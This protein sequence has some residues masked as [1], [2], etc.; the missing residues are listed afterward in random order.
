[1][2]RDPRRL[3]PLSSAIQQ[4][5]RSRELLSPLFPTPHLGIPNLSLPHATS[6]RQHL[7]AFHPPLH[8]CKRSRGQVARDRSDDADQ[9]VAPENRTPLPRPFELLPRSNQDPSPLCP[10]LRQR[11]SRQLL[12]T[13]ETAN[14]EKTHHTRQPI[15]TYRATAI[16]APEPPTAPFPLPSRDTR[17]FSNC[18]PTRGSRGADGSTTLGRGK[19]DQKSIGVLSP[20]LPFDRFLSAEKSRV[21]YSM[22]RLRLIWI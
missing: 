7:V 13:I 18:P 15:H 8:P 22:K 19:R 11:P 6:S 4:P 17:P 12:E 14:A 5:L 9:T 16:L 1:M 3:S 20:S 2:R 21:G 10:T